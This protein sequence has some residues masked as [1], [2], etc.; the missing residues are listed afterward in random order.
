MSRGAILALT[1]VTLIWKPQ[2]AFAC[3]APL[4]LRNA[5]FRARGGCLRIKIK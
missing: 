2:M 1:T 5:G 3:R 4:K